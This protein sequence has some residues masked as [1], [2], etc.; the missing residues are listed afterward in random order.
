VSAPVE[1]KIL[2][3]ISDESQRNFILS[4]WLAT[5]KK[6]GLVNSMPDQRYFTRYRP[7]VQQ[8]I[9]GSQVAFAVDPKDP[10]LIM[11]YIV[12]RSVGGVP[13]VSMIYIKAL[14]RRLAIGKRLFEFAKEKLGAQDEGVVA[15]H[16]FRFLADTFKRYGVLYDPFFDLQ[17]IERDSA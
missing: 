12:Y 9:T 5:N 11:G 3:G 6:A 8:V 10:F 2:E 4:S 15:T 13:V 14:Y 17:H 16:S 1:I 7:I